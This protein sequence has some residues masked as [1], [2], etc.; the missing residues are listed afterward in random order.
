LPKSRISQDHYLLQA[1]TYFADMWS[2]GFFRNQTIPMG[3][4][5]KTKKRVLSD[6]D[7][8]AATQVYQCANGSKHKISYAVKQL[9]FTSYH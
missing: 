4:Q 8:F 6:E 7:L 3:D 5:E 2:V 9:T 1:Y